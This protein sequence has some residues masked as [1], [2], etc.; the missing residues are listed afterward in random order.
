MLDCIKE[1]LL[2]FTITLSLP[3]VQFFIQLVFPCAI[4]S[5]LK[6]GRGQDG[7]FLIITTSLLSTFHCNK[8]G[9]W[10]KHSALDSAK[11]H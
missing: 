8:G 1:A 6:H 2:K 9:A 4:N 11:H 3:I 5:P 7:Q 10:E